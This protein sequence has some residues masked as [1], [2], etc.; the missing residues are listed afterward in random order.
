MPIGS[1]ASVCSVPHA[2][3]HHDPHPAVRDAQRREPVA[4]ERAAQRATA[5]DHET[6]PSPGVS[7][8]ARTSALSSCTRTVAIGPANAA[9]PRS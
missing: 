4:E 2:A 6:R 8:A 1:T 5:V 9:P 7:S 3:V